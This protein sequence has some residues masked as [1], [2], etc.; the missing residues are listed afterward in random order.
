MLPIKG[1]KEK[2][3]DYTENNFNRRRNKKM[4]RIFFWSLVLFLFFSFFA[5]HNFKS[6]SSPDSELFGEPVKSQLSDD[7]KIQFS[8]D[9]FAFTLTPLY[10]YE[11]S[12]LVVNKLNYE[13]FSLTRS[14]NIFPVDLCL[15]WGENV[16]SKAYR[17]KSIGF[18]QD[19]RFCFGYWSSEASFSWAEVSNNH[20]VIK[21]QEIRKKVMSIVEGDQIRLKGKLVNVEAKNIDGKLG[22]YESQLSNW[23]SSVKLGDSGAGACEVIFVEDLE[24]IKKGNPL[25]FYGFQVALWIFLLFVFYKIIK[26]FH[27]LWI[28]K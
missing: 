25:F 23:N 3:V 27:E 12:A 6:V 1:Q 20:L 16:K 9:G 24:I 8:Q 21:D 15:T 13:R 5:R 26:F 10:E 4:E 7:K 28:K 22:K 14:D 18:R 19:A 11:M 17:H 2:S